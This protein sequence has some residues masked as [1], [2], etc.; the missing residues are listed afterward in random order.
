MQSDRYTRFRS[1]GGN[2]LREGLEN[3]FSGTRENIA[4]WFQKAKENSEKI[5][6]RV[7]FDSE[8]CHTSMDG[9]LIA[10]YELIP[11]SSPD[12]STQSFNAGTLL[13]HNAVEWRYMIYTAPIQVANVAILC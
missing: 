9:A 8:L 6:E 13:I 4:N 1:V 7:V 11:G 12:L 5:V 2:S 10:Y 3:F